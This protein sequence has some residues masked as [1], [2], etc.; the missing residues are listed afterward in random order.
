MALTVTDVA[1]TIGT[2][3]IVL[4]P[5]YFRHFVTNNVLKNEIKCSR[6]DDFAEPEGVSVD[7][8][9][10][11]SGVL[12]LEDFWHRFVLEVM[13]CGPKAIILTCPYNIEVLRAV[14][15]YA[16]IRY[17]AV[18]STSHKKALN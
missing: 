1:Q 14:P 4:D 17:K 10:K 6:L 16:L 3:S 2:L 7:F 5:S 13:F 18:P 9:S 11:I 15:L 12:Q 8:V